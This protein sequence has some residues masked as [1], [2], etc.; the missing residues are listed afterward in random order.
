[1]PRVKLTRTIEN[2]LWVVPMVLNNV[3]IFSNVPLIMRNGVEGYHSIGI[4]RSPGTKAFAI[5]CNAGNTGL[6]AFPF[7]KWCLISACGMSG[8]RL[9]GF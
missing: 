7:G 9:P 6:L 3:E 5:T 2:R 1:M 8:S 4:E